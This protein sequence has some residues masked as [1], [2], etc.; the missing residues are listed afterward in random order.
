MSFV[1][2]RF[3]KRSLTEVE[4]LYRRV[5]SAFDMVNPIPRRQRDFDAAALCRSVTAKLRGMN[6]LFL[7]DHH[8]AVSS[9][10]GNVRVV[11][12]SGILSDR[13][14]EIAMYTARMCALWGYRKDVTIVLAV[15]PV[16]KH[17]WFDRPLTMN[18]INSGVTFPE[19]RQI[20]MFRYDDD[21]FKVLCHELVHLCCGEQDE[22]VTECKALL[23]H[24]MAT[25]SSWDEFHTV[26]LPRQLELS[27]RNASIIRDV[28][29]GKTNAH[30]Y[31]CIGEDMLE[32]AEQLLSGTYRRH[33]QQIKRSHRH[34][35]GMDW[36]VSTS[37]AAS[38]Y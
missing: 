14:N 20:I 10:A 3:K 33:R 22:A 15:V 8:V 37:G 34:E 19:D 1:S 36:T 5:A 16:K 11:S 17:I 18:D 7:A 27:R 23:V 2:T 13:T 9:T 29:P 32:H 25:S 12:L 4:T 38:H 28:D 35:V 30:L 6:V 21:F 31:W 26:K 24:T